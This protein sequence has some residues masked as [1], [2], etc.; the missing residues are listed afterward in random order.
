M[1]AVQSVSARIGRVTGR[2]LA[3]NMVKVFPRPV[4][5]CWCC[6]CSSPTPSISAPTWRPWAPPRSWC[7]AAAQHLYTVALRAGLPDRRS[8]SFPIT[9]MSA[10]LKW[11]TF[12]LFAYVGVVFTVQID[13]RRSRTA[14][15][16]PRFDLSG[17]ALTLVVADLRHH[18]Q[19]LPLLLAELAGSRGGGGRSGRRPLTRASPSRRRASC[20]ASAGR[21]GPAWAMSNLVAF[22]IM[23]TTAATLHANGQT[24]IQT[25]EQAAEALRPIAG[26]FAFLLF[27]LGIIG[28]GLLA[29]PVLAGSAAYA[30]GEAARLAR[31]G[32]SIRQRGAAVLRRDRRGHPARHRPRSS[33]R[34]IRSRR[35][36]GA[37]SST[38]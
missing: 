11:L 25:A 1:V 17:E 9:A 28:T 33:R 20:G 6:C 27:S 18:H 3:G 31:P 35:W 38:A 8:C 19:P 5:G 15:F 21:P 37:P 13:W 12:S 29:V 24:D 14:R 4:V 10:L 30:V 34:S 22:S 7:S 2:G 16:V 36:S 32:W 23:L 26:D